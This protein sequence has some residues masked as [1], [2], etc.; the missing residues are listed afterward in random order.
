MCPTEW[1][2]EDL[3]RQP[4]GHLAFGDGPH[5]CLGSHLARAQIIAML[6]GLTRRFPTMRLDGPTTRM[7]SNFINGIRNLQSICTRP[8]VA[9]EAVPRQRAKAKRV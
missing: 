4:N 5:F 2:A 1:L 8:D 6:G 7:R 9:S 3:K